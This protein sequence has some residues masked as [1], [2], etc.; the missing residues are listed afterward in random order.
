M[1][2]VDYLNQGYENQ[3]FSKNGI[4]RKIKLSMN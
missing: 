3:K 1:G 2:V 4:D